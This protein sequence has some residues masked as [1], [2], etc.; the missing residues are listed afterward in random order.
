MST[1]KFIAEKDI[2]VDEV[3]TLH[4]I[5]CGNHL[6]TY[7]DPMSKQEFVRMCTKMKFLMI[8]DFVYCCECHPEQED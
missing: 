6:S 4:C 7:Q 1:Y 5:Q 2:D 8:D 3:Y